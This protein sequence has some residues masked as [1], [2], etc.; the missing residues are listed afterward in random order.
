MDNGQQQQP[1]LREAFIQ[2]HI[3][4]LL[5][6]FTGVF[7]KLITLNETTLVW[8]RIFFAA[9]ILMVFTGFPRVGWRKFFQILGSGA[10]LGLHWLL[11]YASIKMS[12]ISIGVVCFASLS[13]FTAIFA[14]IINKRRIIWTELLFSLITIAGLVCIFS[15]STEYRTG[16]LIGLVS[17]ALCSLYAITTQRVSVGQRT[18]DVLS[19]SMWG[20]LAGVSI[21][22]PLY[23]H[24]FPSSQ[25]VM[26]FPEGANLWWLLSLSLFCTVG[27]YLLQI[28]CMRRLSAF[29]VNL[30]YN[31]EP[32]YSILIAFVAF[33]ESRE[34]NF[35]FYV[36]IALVIL[37]VVLQTLRQW[38]NK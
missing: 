31:L 30:T 2:L 10:L 4:A 33:G 11:F 28:M 26:V 17:A 12:N 27:L 3:S 15:F 14:P 34:L 16:I 24:F 18:R 8:Y 13:F 23:L 35:S 9:V 7:G 5:A 38:K 20:A 19:Y 6:G 25:P 1:S 36:G 21:M 22:S 37:S 29:T 32:C